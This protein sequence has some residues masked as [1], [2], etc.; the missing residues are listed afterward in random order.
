MANAQSVGT[1]SLGAGLRAALMVPWNAFVAAFL[2]YTLLT[3][4]AI[5][6]ADLPNLFVAVAYL[7]PP[8]AYLGLLATRAVNALAALPID[9]GETP[10][11]LQH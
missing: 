1:R 8:A 4:L 2:Y 3:L 7:L 11:A 10:H 5:G 9:I 6:V